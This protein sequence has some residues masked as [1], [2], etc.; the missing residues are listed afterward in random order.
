MGGDVINTD[1]GWK[2]ARGKVNIEK[3]IVAQTEDDHYCVIP[4]ADIGACEATTDKVIGLPMS[5]VELESKESAISPEYWFDSE[6][7]TASG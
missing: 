4:R 7:V 1:K 5:A 3:L 2:R 6:E